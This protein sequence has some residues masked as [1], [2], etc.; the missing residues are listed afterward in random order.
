MFTPESVQSP[1]EALALRWSQKANSLCFSLLPSLPWCFIAAIYF[2]DYKFY[3]H[4]CFQGWPFSPGQ[5][6]SELSLGEGVTSSPPSFTQLLIVLCVELSPCKLSSVQF[7]WQVHW[8]PQSSS[9]I[10]IAMLVRPYGSL[11]FCKKCTIFCH[12]L[13]STGKET[14]GQWTKSSQF[15]TS[16][17]LF[18]NLHFQFSSLCSFVAVKWDI[19]KRPQSWQ[20]VS[21]EKVPASASVSPAHPSVFLPNTTFTFLSIFM[22]RWYLVSLVS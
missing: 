16:V 5:P 18:N 22:S 1:D 6:T 20:R 12:Y 13:Q 17:V 7:H 3:L 11:Y 8:C 10:W 14:K 21:K 9:H 19:I 4:V 15:L 2:W